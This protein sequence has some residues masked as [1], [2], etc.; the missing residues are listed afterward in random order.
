MSWNLINI[1]PMIKF[2]MITLSG[3]YCSFNF[4]FH[5]ILWN[6]I[7]DSQLQAVSVLKKWLESMSQV[8]YH[9]YQRTHFQQ[10]S[11]S[12]VFVGYH[13]DAPASIVLRLSKE[14]GS[15]TESVIEEVF[16]SDFLINFKLEHIIFFRVGPF[17]PEGAMSPIKRHPNP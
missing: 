4:K 9:L 3:F 17:F 16:Y 15:T 8:N 1:K 6:F 13:D 10:F 12:D 11:P 2:T 7:P 5:L 14:N